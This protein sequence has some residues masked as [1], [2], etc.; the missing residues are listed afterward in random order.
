MIRTKDR[1]D[2]WEPDLER[3]VKLDDPDAQALGT[4]VQALADP[5]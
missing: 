3:E 4:V 5:E 1:L 2:A